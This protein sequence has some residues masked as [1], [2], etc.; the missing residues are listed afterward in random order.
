MGQDCADSCDADIKLGMLKIDSRYGCGIDQKLKR[1]LSKNIPNIR[2][3]V[4]VL[5]DCR[6]LRL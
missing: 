1:K 6:N 5:N 3:Q 2:V 4:F